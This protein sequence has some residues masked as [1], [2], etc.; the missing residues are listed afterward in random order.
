[1]KQGLFS[2]ILCSLLFAG[3]S[4]VQSTPAGSSSPQ[5]MIQANIKS[6]EPEAIA[7][8]QKGLA[9]KNAFIRSYAIESVAVTQRREMMPQILR[10]LKDPIVGVRFAAAVGAGD[11]QCV[12][13]A[14]QIRPLLQD[15][16]ESVRIA[17]AYALAKLHQPQHKDVI[18]DSLKSQDQTAR[19]NSALLLGKLGDRTD[20]PLLYESLSDADSSDKVRMQ[21]VE[22]IARLGDEKMYRSKLWALQISKFADDRVIGIR[23]MG[24]LNTAE[25]RNAILTML[26]DDIPEVRL[27]AAEQLARLGDKRGEQEVFDYL[28]TQADLNQSSMANSMAIMAVGRLNSVRLNPYLTKAIRSQSAYLQI[29]AAESVLLLSK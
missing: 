20:L 14:E 7:I 24:A 3:C 18:R 28:Q 17:A 2:I 13:C 16:N 23:G 29:I 12:G 10:L 26:T 21:A 15:E 5:P 4:F 9:D 22:S 8:L 1:M 27:A 6:L 19:A 11:M 25:S